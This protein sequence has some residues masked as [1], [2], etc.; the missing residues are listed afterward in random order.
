[1]NANA[2]REQMHSRRL[3]KR[4]WYWAPVKSDATSPGPSPNNAFVNGVNA[5][6]LT[7]FAF[8]ALGRLGPAYFY[9][10]SAF[11][12]QPV[13]TWCKIRTVV[14]FYPIVFLHHLG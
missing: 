1:M 13:S 2:A 12:A 5:F 4:Y 3:Q 7:T 11:L 8:T 9:H 6:A 14:H 10:P